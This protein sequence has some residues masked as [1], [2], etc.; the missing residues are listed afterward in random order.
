[1]YPKL[2]KNTDP[3]VS[4]SSAGVTDSISVPGFSSCLPYKVL[5]DLVLLG[6]QLVSLTQ[7]R[8]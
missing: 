7:S 8:C 3:F 2:A 5:Q 1:M 6:P 4:L